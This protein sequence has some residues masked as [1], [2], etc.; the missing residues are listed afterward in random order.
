MNVKGQ[1]I[2]FLVKYGFQIV[3]GIIIFICGLF[4]ASALGRL[5]KKSL[6]R[7]KLDQPVEMLL[8]RVTKLIVILLAGILTVA[9]MGVDIAPLVAGMG[10]IG[11]GIGLATQ[12]VLANLVAGLLIIFAKPFRVGE[13]IDLLGEA[14]VVQSIDL[15]ST[16]LAHYDKSI[17]VIPNRKIVGEVL[18]NYGVIR[19]LDLVVGVTYDSDLGLVERTVKDVLTRCPRVLKDPAAFYGVAELAD[20]SIDI[21]IKP[22]V[23]VQY[24]ASAS[25]EIY[26]AI[27]EAFRVHNIEMPF[28]QSE[29]RIL[30]PD[31]IRGS[32]ALAS[33]GARPTTGL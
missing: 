21:A 15:F 24:F 25:G 26:Q 9:K 1:V 29:I 4:I 27:L 16:K 14:G 7:F 20:S 32:Q 13:Y 22:W 10:V 28:P 17:V 2:E 8:V 12:G 5:V 23:S 11:V 30:N 19:Q 31:S 18:H 3:G 6:T 33:S